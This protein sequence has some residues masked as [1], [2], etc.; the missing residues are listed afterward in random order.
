MWG[1][2]VWS[3]ANLTNEFMFEGLNELIT[4]KYKMRFR[5]Y[6]IVY[7]GDQMKYIELRVKIKQEY[8]EEIN[9]LAERV[10]DELHDRAEE[11]DF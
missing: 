8:Q 9:E 5:K 10:K 4:Y 11:L 1:L 7:Y 3:G 6:S 2:R